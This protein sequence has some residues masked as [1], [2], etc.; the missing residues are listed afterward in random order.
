MLSAGPSRASTC[1]LLLAAALLLVVGA[2]ADP[3]G[4][5]LAW[6]AAAVLALAGLR[7]LLLSPVL[8][9]DE[10]GLEVVVGLRRRWAPWAQLEGARVVTDR[11]TALLELDLGD[12]LLVLP[13]RRLGRPP[14]VVLEQLL[15]LQR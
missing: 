12:T 2:A 15:Q 6:P 11:R 3:G 4:R 1:L 5:V 13:R 10:I 9:A 8:R 7:D 14:E